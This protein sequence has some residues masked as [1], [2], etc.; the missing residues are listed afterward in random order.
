MPDPQSLTAVISDKFKS[1][2]YRLALLSLLAT[3]VLAYAGKFDLVVAGG[4]ATVLG[5]YNRANT[6]QKRDLLEA[7]AEGVES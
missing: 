4:I 2:K 1:R 6:R 5:L 7:K 3:V